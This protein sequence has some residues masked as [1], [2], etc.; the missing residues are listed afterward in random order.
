MPML[1]AGELAKI[2]D[3]AQISLALTDT[4]IADELIACAKDSRSLK[5]VI[6]FD[7]TSNHDAELDR[8]A[9]DKPVK[10]DA[11]QTGR[12]GRGT[13]WFYVGHDR[14]AKGDDAFPSRPADH[15]R[16]LCT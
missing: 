16:W 13:A 9:L 7:G 5:Q 1:R 14:R 4:R 15:C 8:V 12:D 11:V 10:F 2:V 3:K 6:G